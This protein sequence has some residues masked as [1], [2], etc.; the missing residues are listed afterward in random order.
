MTTENTLNLRELANNN[1][2]AKYVFE[3][4]A[5]RE[6]SAARSDIDAIL[7]EIE[8]E[9]KQEFDYNEYLEVWRSIESSGAGRMIY[10]RRGNPNRFIWD[11]HLK[12][13]GKSAV[14]S[15][16]HIDPFNKLKSNIKPK[17][18]GK[19]EVKSIEK[20]P[21]PH[22]ITL[23]IPETVSKEDLMAFLSLGT[24]LIRQPEK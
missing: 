20:K 14:T 2:L 10:G 13:L 19:E 3:V 24:S 23:V 1:K 11:T 16:T 18:E 21:E 15:P 6:R 7:R 8:A 12:T 17:V 22:T 5:S 4:L 9:H